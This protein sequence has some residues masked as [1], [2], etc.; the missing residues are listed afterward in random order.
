LPGIAIAMSAE[1]STRAQANEVTAAPSNIHRNSANQSV[2]SD[3]QPTTSVDS[4][5]TIAPT[6]RAIDS[7]LAGPVDFLGRLDESFSLSA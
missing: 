7:L 3:A 1:T 2:A 5:A 6:V 4:A